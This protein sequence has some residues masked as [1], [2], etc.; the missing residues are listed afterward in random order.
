MVDLHCLGDGRYCFPF[1]SVFQ[2]YSDLSFL[3]LPILQFQ[4]THQHQRYVLPTPLSPSPFFRFIS[5]F[6]VTQISNFSWLRCTSSTKSTSTVCLLSFLSSVS[7]DG[8]R[9]CINGVFP[10]SQCV[11][12]M[13][14]VVLQGAALAF[15]NCSFD[16]FVDRLLLSTSFLVLFY[17]LLV[18]FFIEGVLYGFEMWVIEIFRWVM[19]CC[20]CV[21]WFWSDFK[22]LLVDPVTVLCLSS[23]D[24]SASQLK[25]I[26]L[27]FEFI[28]ILMFLLLSFDPF[29][30]SGCKF[31]LV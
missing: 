2:F 6:S 4:S 10:L 14:S 11:N 27:L 1:A 18:T 12:P 24:R 23:S 8:W 15:A 21:S 7:G 25:I 22:L 29:W 26:W 3:P 9:G 13:L 17:F 28:C 5:S 19:F 31:V 16:L 20:A 30:I